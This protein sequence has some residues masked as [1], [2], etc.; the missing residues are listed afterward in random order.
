MAIA[1][2]R[3]PDRAVALRTVRVV[4]RTGARTRGWLTAGAMQIPVAL[5]RSGTRADKR[6]GDG[7]TP[8]GR[9]RPVRVWWRADRGL[10][11]RTFLPVRRIGPADAWCE[12]PTD[13]RYNRRIR[14][15]DEQVGDHL[16]RADHLYDLFVELDHNVRPRIARRGSAIFVHV[17]RPGLLPTAGCVALPVACL[18]RLV[19]RIGRKTR[20]LIH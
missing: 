1:S 8:R 9:F 19:G 16:W 2:S 6:E 13:R 5:G 12:D 4:T 14:V 20:I 7:A 15:P 11:P 3:V 17:A 10:R 18:R